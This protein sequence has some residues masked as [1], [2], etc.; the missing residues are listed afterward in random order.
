MRSFIISTLLLAILMPALA[1]AHD[2][3]VDGIYYNIN[4]NEAAVTFRGRYCNSFYN[5]YSG[6]VVI[7]AT[8]TYN[9]TTYPVT[10]IDTLAFY[11][12]SELTSIEI[13]NSITEIG[14]EA[15]GN[16]PGLT[17]IVVESSNPK[18]DSRNNCNAIIETAD[19]TLIVG[20]KNTT[21]PNS[22]TAIGNF[23]FERCEGLTSIDIPNSVTHIGWYA[24][25]SC[26]GLTSI[27]IPNSVTE[28]GVGAFEW[29]TELTN[30]VV[31]SGNPRYD[32]RNNCNAIMETADN[33]LIV[34]CKNT[35]IPNSVIE[36]GGGAFSNC[37][38][39]TSIDIPNS[40]TYI[41]DAAFFSC[42]GLTRIV[43]PNSVTYI[44]EGA[45]CNCYGLTSIVIPNSEIEIGDDAFYNCLRLADVYSYIADLS[46]V[47]SGNRQFSL[48]N[49]DYS[50]RTLHVLQGTADAY[51]ADVNWYPYFG[52]IVEDIFMGDV[53]G[54]LEVNIADVNAVIDIILGGSGNTVAADVNG[55]GEINIADINAVIDIILGR[56]AE[57]EPEH[58]WVDLG[59]PSGTLWATCN[60]GANSPEEFGHHFAWGETE[61][62]DV[63]DWSTYKWCNGSY[64]TITKYCT[65]SEYGYNGFV[66]N[67][68]ELDLEDDAAYVNWGPSWCMPTVEQQQELYQNCSSV[69]TTKN[70]V[71]GR[72]FTGPNGNT[73]FLPAAG[74]RWDGSLYY[75]GSY[76]YYWSRTLYT[77]F[78]RS[79]LAYNLDFTSGYVGCDGDDRIIGFTVR[80]VRVSQN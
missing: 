12:C 50:R 75:V 62:K 68:T 28:I 73:L 44:G 27:V 48:D 26:E 30:I 5:E 34:G 23:A 41:G 4:G 45:F 37:E 51:R 71:N 58:D 8:V 42:V 6:S 52:Q 32:S 9:G 3:E 55:D 74:G 33:T 77:C 63:Y 13:P 2:F 66:D 10:S 22:V 7:P 21:I 78:S 72:L 24:F 25:Y 47:S 29:C 59:L 54:D 60:V 64:T 43:I 69:W 53:N 17:S 14:Q 79:D 31:E 18:Y 65:N 19:N 49:G 76:G 56:N 20:C 40:V 46:R 16:C 57:P 35:T 80:A 70:G 67:K 61:P 38:G 39:L 1:T 11:F 36:I 15:F